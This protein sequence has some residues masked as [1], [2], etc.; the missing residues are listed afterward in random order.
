MSRNA[1]SSALILLGLACGIA[2]GSGCSLA[3]T[4]AI[5]KDRA[6]DVAGTVPV[7]EHSNQAAATRLA[8]GDRFNRSSSRDA[9]PSQPS[10]DSIAIDDATEPLSTQ[11]LLVRGKNNEPPPR[12]IALPKT[13]EGPAESKSNEPFDAF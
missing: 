13:D 6:Q 1:R 5:Q 2:A 7:E 9:T 3:R 8:A 11:W 12:R 10:G 4:Y